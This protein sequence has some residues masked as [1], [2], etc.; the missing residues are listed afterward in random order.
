MPGC[1]NGGAGPTGSALHPRRTARPNPTV[2]FLAR[3][4]ARL[5]LHTGAPVLVMESPAVVARTTI[6]EV[7]VAGQ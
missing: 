7:T 5:L 4:L 3:D 2:D 6:R 1:A